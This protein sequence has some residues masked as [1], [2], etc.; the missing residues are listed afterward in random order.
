M[1][2]IVRGQ[3]SIVEGP[4][5]FTSNSDGSGTTVRT[6]S[7]LQADILAL[8]L[9][10]R[11][12]GYSTEVTQATPWTMRATLAMNINNGPVETEPRST[13]TVQ[14][15]T[16]EGNLL[17][18]GIPFI[19]ELSTDTKERILLSVKNPAKGIPLT[20]PEHSSELT[21]A[22]KVATLLKIGVDSIRQNQVTVSRTI[23]VSKRYVCTWSF[24]EQNKVLSKNSLVTLFNVPQWVQVLLPESDKKLIHTAD[25]VT[26]ES[27]GA[28]LM[29]FPNYQN[30]A[31]DQVQI[32]QNWH[33]NH[34]VTTPVL[35][36]V[37]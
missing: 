17:E 36:T 7:G 16:G 6:F 15:S 28:Y 2:A 20:S 23:T 25:G 35:Y 10:L 31:N 12:V 37:V 33:Y 27:T 3:T 21:D 32:Q 26:I 29:D 4:S 9:N 13:W 1:A 8:E 18:S 5:T 34:W 11:A 22:R 30:V 24:T 19:A 14:A